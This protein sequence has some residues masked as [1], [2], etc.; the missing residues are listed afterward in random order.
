[1]VVQDFFFLFNRSANEQTDYL[2]V[3]DQRRPWTTATE[4]LRVR[5]RSF[6]DKGFGESGIEEGLGEGKDWAFGNLNHTA[7]HNAVGCFA[8]RPW[9]HSDRTDPFVPKI[10]SGIKLET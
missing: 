3:S 6:R 10:G 7:K 5:C 2:M 8:V 4:E 9:Y 1:M